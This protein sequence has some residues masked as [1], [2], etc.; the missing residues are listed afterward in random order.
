M[1]DKVYHVTTILKAHVAG[2]TTDQRQL[3]KIEEALTGYVMQ[4]EQFKDA[5]QDRRRKELHVLADEFVRAEILTDGK[6]E[7]ITCTKGCAHCCK[8]I[9]IV[10]QPEGARLFQLA[11]ERGIPL[12]A[13]R[14]ARQA[15]QDDNG[16]LTL[17]GDDRNCPFLGTDN[18]CQV[19]DDRPLSCRKYFVVSDP[20]LCD[21]EKHPM[22]LVC[23]CYSVDAEVLTTAAFTALGSSSMAQALLAEIRREID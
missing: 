22:D 5:H 12:D 19:Y 6:P 16:W 23:V 4:L 17:Q 7:H 15:I 13:S 2:L 8:Q 1:D 10:T 11:N 3:D 20:E 14:L 18:T 9:V 21:I